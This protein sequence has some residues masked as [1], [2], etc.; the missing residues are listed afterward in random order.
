MSSNRPHVGLALFL[1][2]LYN[3]IEGIDKEDKLLFRQIVGGHAL[4]YF[5]TSNSKPNPQE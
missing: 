3:M 2:A 5:P 1:G 4:S